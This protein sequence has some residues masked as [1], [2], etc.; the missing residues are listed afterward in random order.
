MGTLTDVPHNFLQDVV[1][2]AEV[3]LASLAERGMRPRARVGELR[4]RL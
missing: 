4:L 1:D 3:F 2:H